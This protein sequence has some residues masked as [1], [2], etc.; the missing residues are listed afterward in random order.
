MCTHTCM[1]GCTHSASSVQVSQACTV[2][3]CSW[4]WGMGAGYLGPQGMESLHVRS[5]DVLVC[6]WVLSCVQPCETT[7]IVARQAPLSM[8]LSGQE[9]WSG[10]PCPPPGGFPT[11]GSNLRLLRIYHW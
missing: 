5:G 1:H 3:G 4:V 10:L 9:Y 8:G 6:L 11:Q 7:W 2:H